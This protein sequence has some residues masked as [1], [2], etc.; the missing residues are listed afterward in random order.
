[1][2][3]QDRKANGESCPRVSTMSSGVLQ[4]SLLASVSGGPPHGAKGGH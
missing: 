4:S 3:S 1:M 2:G